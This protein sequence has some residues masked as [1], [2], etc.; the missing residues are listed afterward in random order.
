MGDKGF[1][2][3]LREFEAEKTTQ[4]TLNQVRKIIK[5]KDFDPKII[6][7]KAKAAACLASW[8][9]ALEKYAEIRK[10]IKPMEDK[11]QEAEAEY[12]E[13][14]QKLVK[15][16]AALKEARDKVQAYETKYNETI[17]EINRLND[18][19]KE[20]EI[21][22][23][24]ASKLI[25]LTKEEGENW[26][27]TVG[28][29]KGDKDKLI[30]DVFLGTSSISYIG[31]FTGVYR[32]KI[33]SQWIEKLIEYEIPQSEKYK[34]TNTL[35]DAVKIRNWN[36]A[37]LP[38]DSVS[39]DN[40]IMCDR[41]ERWP[42]LIDPQTQAN[43]WIRNSFP[44]ELKVVKLSETDTY[45][46]IVDTALR[47]GH[48]VL[49][50]D[51]LEE[52]DPALDN[53]LQ[54]AIFDNNGLPTIH[55]GGK[56][57]TYDDHFKL[58][59]TSKLPNPHY[60]PEICIKLTIINFTVT[61]E[62]L[63]EQMLVDVV[64]QEKPQVEKKRDELI[65]KLAKLES[66]KRD[67]EIQIL[68]TL[69]DSNEETILDG[70]ELIQILQT[71]KDK[72]GFIKEKLKEAIEIEAEI[73]ET[74]NQYK[75]VSIRGSILYFVITDL[76]II[77]PMYQY[78]LTYVKKL[79]NDAIRDS[80]G[81]DDLDERIEVLIK[82]ITKSI[83]NNICRGLFENHKMIYSFLICTSIE[84]NRGDIETAAWN[85][86]LRG[87]G[88]FDD[89]EEPDNPLPSFIKNEDWDL[90]YALEQEYPSKLEGLCESMRL[91]PQ[92]WVKFAQSDDPTEAW[93]PC[94]FNEKLDSFEK[95]IILKIF[96][97][98]SLSIAFTK[99]VSEKL[100]AYY[101][102]SPPSTMEGLYADSDKVTPV[103][104]VLS[105][106][107]DPTNQLIKFAES[108]DYIDKFKYI[109]LGQGQDK[110][111]SK[112]IEEGKKD[113]FWIL[114]QNCHLFKSWMLEL[115][116]IVNGFAEDSGINPDFRLFLTS[117]PVNYFPV[118]V[119]QNGLKLTTE[120]PK[121]IK[122]NMKRS[123]NELTEK[124]F[125]H[126][127]PEWNRLLFG[128]CFFHAIVQE[129]RKFGPLGW[130]I[131]YQFNESDLDTSRI[132]LRN[133]LNEN[134]KTP[135]DSMTFMTGQINYGGRVTDDLDRKLLL[136]ILGKYYTPD[137]L[138][139]GYRFSESGI[140]YAPQLKTL[141]EYRDHIDTLPAND[142]PEVF[143]MHENA[144]LSFK[145]NE[146]ANILAI[147][148][149]I[150]PR[151]TGGGEGMSGDDIIL[152][153]ILD[154]QDRLPDL[155]DKN[156]CA[157]HLFKIDHDGLMHCLATVLLQEIEKF[158]NLLSVMES[159]L[160][161]LCNAIQGKEI[162]SQE[163][164]EMYSAF[165]KNQVPPNWVAV[166][167]PSLKPLASWIL[168]LLRR[169]EFMR[170]WCQEGHPKCFW[171][172]GFFFPHGFM[173]GTLQTFAR[174]HK[175]AVDLL[176]YSFE[177]LKI[178]DPEDVQKAPSDGIYVNGLFIEA[179]QWNLDRGALEDQK[180]SQSAQNALP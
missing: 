28:I 169:V 140:Y 34:L 106:G 80:Q 42:L 105:Q 170:V 149:D 22:L 130:N 86:L 63:E 102:E 85:F 59:M 133:F 74:R 141:E 139:D 161:S 148:L 3:R 25:N 144:N 77:D 159:S 55:F 125:A 35:G 14:N 57:V 64:I 146:S 10:E 88:I 17:D 158:N 38:S 127:K 53:I 132:M 142:D 100:G 78:S 118:S 137:I 68:K 16:N 27:E 101:S 120:P 122:A 50:E 83:Y 76:A 65:I 131:R 87:P 166:A 109:S 1:L 23:Q 172:P 72:A 126:D 121:G 48:I 18:G 160:I 128:L 154:F 111:A 51:V 20:N 176:Q 152:G 21:K 40:G 9:I 110:V 43:Q 19:I 84:K 143:G 24:R 115:E 36:M 33:L 66:D 113:G 15:S 167:Y 8:C 147:I 61:F 96:R 41:S 157:K 90:A 44:E 75:Q 73:T 4:K 81:P 153:S 46:K 49:I 56:D 60:L 13:A 150:Q 178:V 112:L 54:K 6:E 52:I 29:L 39:I 32:E 97:P 116:N 138:E 26:K 129:R 11:L 124:D 155:I 103:I 163:L 174:K 119:L 94:G 79:F 93:I 31:P 71:S 165:L 47:L 70:D 98:E 104:F 95:L 134:E 62:G 173:T 117:M 45:P 151:T 91:E 180:A 92:H 177:V 108:K 114:L 168:D 135:W 37:G 7:G 136:C 123:Y 175:V 162:M 179:A 82:N 164:D 67:V 156:D 2:Q 107:A 58:F 99:Y 89:S 145:I 69:A 171:L 30:G 5:K 12:N